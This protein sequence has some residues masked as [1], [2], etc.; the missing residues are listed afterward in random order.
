VLERRATVQTLGL[1]LAALRVEHAL[2]AN[3][4][5]RMADALFATPAERAL[6]DVLETERREIAEWVCSFP[7]SGG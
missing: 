7:P 1:E 5:S 6:L 2:Q 4:I 3:L